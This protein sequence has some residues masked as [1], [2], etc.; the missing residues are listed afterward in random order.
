MADNVSRVL[1]MMHPMRE[2]A[3][4]A[5]LA[6]FLVT[7]AIGAGAGVVLFVLIIQARRR[8]SLVRRAAV[9]ELARTRAL[10]PPERLAAQASLLRR[11]VR[12]LAGES[13]ARTQGALWLESLDRVFATRFFTEG[14]GRAFGDAL[15]GP[16]IPDV[17]ALDAELTGLFA[18]LGTRRHA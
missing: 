6:P 17:D 14:Q 4:P 16:R 15:Y 8:R 11:L 18:K 9:A 5:G 12:R 13:A 2:P 3:Q 1:E 10:V 7:L